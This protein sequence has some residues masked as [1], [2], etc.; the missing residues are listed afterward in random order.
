MKKTQNTPSHASNGTSFSELF[1]DVFGLQAWAEQKKT[2]NARRSVPWQWVLWG[3]L[4]FFCLGFALS[5]FSFWIIFVAIAAAVIAF[6]AR[7]TETVEP[8]VFLLTDERTPEQKKAYQSKSPKSSQSRKRPSRRTP[9]KESTTESLSSVKS[10]EITEEIAPVSK[11]RRQPRKKVANG[12]ENTK[13]PSEEVTVTDATPKGDD[14]PAAKAR[15]RKPRSNTS[16]RTN[17]RPSSKVS[18]LTQP[19][20][21]SSEVSDVSPS[22]DTTNSSEVKSPREENSINSKENVSQ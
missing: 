3:G 16:R 9:N 4:I 11:P 21:P 18:A 15:S 22:I 1:Q 7:S 14:K 17:R 10:A 13:Q 8:Q 19:E 5:H 6:L 20:G 12:K 2:P